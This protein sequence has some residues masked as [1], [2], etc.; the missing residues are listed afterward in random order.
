MKKGYYAHNMVMA[1]SPE[2]RSYSML[3]G[4]G[5]TTSTPSLLDQ[6]VAAG[7]SAYETITATQANVKAQQAAVTTA[8]TTNWL[9]WG[10]LGIGA[11]A[12]IAFAGRKRK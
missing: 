3:D 11:V 8:G 6:I 2:F 1:E 10:V 7:T 12:L 4:L 5:Q 9:L